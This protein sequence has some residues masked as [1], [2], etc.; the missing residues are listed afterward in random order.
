MLQIIYA[1]STTFHSY[2][3]DVAFPVH[4]AIPCYKSF[5]SVIVLTLVLMVYMF[6]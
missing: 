2:V 3:V 6:P 4:E 5:V 1:V